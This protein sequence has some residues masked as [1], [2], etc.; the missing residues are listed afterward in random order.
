MPVVLRF[1][2]AGNSLS[3]GMQ[4]KNEVMARDVLEPLSKSSHRYRYRVSLTIPSPTLQWCCAMRGGLAV[5]F[6]PS[7]QRTHR[8]PCQ[9]G[10]AARGE[11]V[12]SVLVGR[13]TVC[14]RAAWGRGSKESRA[15]EWWACL[16]GLAAA[17]Q[18][19]G[20]FCALLTRPL[21]L[22]TSQALCPDFSPTLPHIFLYCSIQ[23]QPLTVPFS[24]FVTCSLCIHNRLCLSFTLQIPPLTL[25]VHYCPGF[26]FIW[27]TEFTWTMKNL[28]LHIPV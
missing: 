9:V 19:A 4:E 14:W 3:R 7:L 2:S 20:L 26:D 25:S 15:A 12:M 10:T 8:Y 18:S 6:C 28:V 11:K 23:P 17:Q 27:D 13:Q 24:R 5:R 16:S 1:N 21:L 22:E